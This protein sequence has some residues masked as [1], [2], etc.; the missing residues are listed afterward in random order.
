MTTTDRC[1]YSD[2]PPETCHHCGARPGDRPGLVAAQAR[3]ARRGC[4]EPSSLDRPHLPATWAPSN[5]AGEC[6]CGKPTRDEAWICDPCVETFTNT[7]ADLGALDIE[8]QTT[9]TRMRGLPTEGNSSKSAETPLPWHDK[10]A[11]ARRVLNGLL[12]TWVRFCEEEDVRGPAAGFPSDTIPSKAAWLASRVPGL[13]LLD[14]GPE[15]VDEIT[16]AAAE[17]HRLVFWKR[18][19]RVYL[20]PCGV[21]EADEYGEDCEPCP[22][23]VYAD[24]GEPVGFCEVCGQGVTVVVRQGDLN[25]RLDDRLCTAAEIAR[26]STFLGLDQ[27]R[28][29]V[30]KRV[31]YWHRHKRIA[32]R[33]TDTETTPPAP[34]FRYGEVKVMLYAEFGRNTA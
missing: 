18:R 28:E 22:G 26:L 10:A 24:E 11:N 12:S 34:T 8:V 27:P 29:T 23:D 9:M 19:N 2:L 14:I 5:D 31:L 32:Q 21:V 16:D 1:D 30:R 13:A 7:L 20:G 17:C 33:G 15:C 3:A 6:R 25:Q 4:R